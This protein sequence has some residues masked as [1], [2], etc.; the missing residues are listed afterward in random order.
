MKSKR[1][2]FEHIA[3]NRVQKILD[4]LD[5]LSKCSNKNNYDYN[6]ADVKKMERALKE[7]L[8]EVLSSF[9]KGLNSQKRDDFKF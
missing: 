8:V 3:S 6:D 9:N 4:T 1:E 5:S 2:R 7:K